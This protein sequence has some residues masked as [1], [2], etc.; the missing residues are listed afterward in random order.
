MCIAIAIVAIV[1]L[2]LVL[3]ALIAVVIVLLRS[4]VPIKPHFNQYAE[5]QDL[6]DCDVLPFEN[7]RLYS[8]IAITEVVT[9]GKNDSKKVPVSVFSVDKKKLEYNTSHVSLSFT[10]SLNESSRFIISSNDQNRS[11]Y[12][13]PKSNI[14]SETVIQ[15]SPTKATVY[16]IKG[17]KNAY[18]F[19]EDPTSVPHYD[20][21]ID[22]IGASVKSKTVTI[23]NSD[24]YYVAVDIATD[25]AIEFT[26]NI[27]FFII[28]IN[29]NN[30]YLQDLLFT[31]SQQIKEVGDRIHVP[32]DQEGRNVTLCYIHDPRS[33]NGTNITPQHVHLNIEYQPRVTLYVIYVAVILLP[34]IVFIIIIV[35]LVLCLCYMC[36]NRSRL[37][38]TTHPHHYEP[39]N[40]D[41]T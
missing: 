13:R 10:K 18:D 3:I 31:N 24:Y 35:L 6:V 34:I 20:D 17:E 39:I 38:C 40:T 33:T 22:I 2:I 16:I 26:C 29:G 37:C 25:E 9:S 32:L 14:T 23:E 5:D 41:D 12:M 30:D 28:Y 36:K 8:E 7:S 19:I 4:V 1:M 27:S 21:K 11:L 15:G